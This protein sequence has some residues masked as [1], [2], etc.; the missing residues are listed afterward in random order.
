VS[1]GQ[2]FDVRLPSNPST[3]YQWQIG[4]PLDEAVVKLVGS[5]F[6]RVEPAAL[7]TPSPTPVTGGTFARPGVEP[8]PAPGEAPPSEEVRVGQG[9]LE[10]WRFEG[11]AP[12]RARIELV[13]VRPW[14]TDVAPARVA[15]YSVE[16]R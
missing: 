2:Q 8:P 15:A 11:V 4:P 3:G 16:V 12:G 5:D 13:Y 1:P 10:T 9:G 6:Q 7:P 14:E